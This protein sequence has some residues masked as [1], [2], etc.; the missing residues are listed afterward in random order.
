MMTMETM[1]KK[2]YSKPLTEVIII[3]T[4]GILCGSGIDEYDDVFGQVPG[5]TPGSGNLSV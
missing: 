5:L 4:A 2:I 3:Q 1:E